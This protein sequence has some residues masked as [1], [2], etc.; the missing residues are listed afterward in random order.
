[1]T[2][3]LLAVVLADSPAATPVDPGEVRAGRP[4]AVV[5][6]H[7]L[8][9]S[10]RA[11]AELARRLEEDGFEAYNLDYPSRSAPPDELLAELARQID[12]CCAGAP[13][14]HFVGHSLGGILARAWVAQERPANLGR[15]VMLS[16]PNQ[17]SEI[18][19]R[20]GGTW[21]FGA[22]MGPTARTLGT[23]AGSLPRSLPAPDYELGVIATTGSIN[24]L[25]SMIIPGDD[26]GMVA[27]CRMRLDGMTDFIEVDRTHALVMR[28]ADVARQTALFLREGHFD[29]GADAASADA[30]DCPPT[31]GE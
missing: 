17:G 14:L 8:A 21:L 23:V 6:L 15:V 5:V 11:M 30:A 19:D 20:L 10:S 7:G 31:A 12:A 2:A 3:A 18:V 22:I 28:S 1:M 4:E 24:P 26:D 13:R 27:V 25:G 9:R 16:P 29:H